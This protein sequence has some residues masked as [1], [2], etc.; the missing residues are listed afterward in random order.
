MDVRLI[1]SISTSLLI[2]YVLRSTN[3]E[4]PHYE[5]F[6]TLSLL[7]LLPSSAAWIICR[8]GTNPRDNVT[9]MI[10]ATLQRRA[11]W[12]D[13]RKIGHNLFK[14]SNLRITGEDRFKNINDAL[15]TAMF[16]FA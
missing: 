5:I 12:E 14:D 4:H 13:N 15:P 7:S 10:C 9:W 1:H 3:Y 8:L 2:A 11:K 6:S 16:F